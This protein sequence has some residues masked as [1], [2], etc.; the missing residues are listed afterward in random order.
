MTYLD[1]D[2]RAAL[3]KGLRDA[4]AL[5]EDDDET[6]AGHIALGLL[7]YLITVF[8]RSVGPAWVVLRDLY[9]RPFIDKH[10]G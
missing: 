3:A 2:T 10:I 5:L 9:V 1:A 7:S 8:K 6:G 4:A